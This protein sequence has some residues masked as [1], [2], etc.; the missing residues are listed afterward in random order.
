MSFPNHFIWGAA[1]SAYQI[2][3][4]PLADGAGAS[5]WHHFCQTPGHIAN[6]E[7]GDIACDHYRRYRKDIKLM[8]DLGLQMYRFSTAWGRIFPNGTGKRNQAGLD[9]YQRLV[10][11]LLSAGIAPML[12]LYHWDLPQALQE[13]GG[14][15]NPDSPK[16][17]ADYAATLF[18][19]LD[20]RVAWWVTLNEPWVVAEGGH[21]VGELAPGHQQLTEVPWVMHHQ[22]LAHLHAV[23]AYRELGKNRIGLAVNLEPQHAYTATAAD[24]AAAQRRDAYLNRFFLD[25]LLLGHYPAELAEIFGDAWPAALPLAAPSRAVPRLDFL[26]INYYAN[27][28]VRHHPTH[29][30]NAE[31]VPPAANEPQTAMG[32]RINPEALGELL[33]WVKRRYGDL[34]LIITENGS[35]FADPPLQNDTIDDTQRQA[36]LISHLQAL[37]EAIAA[38][39]N[40]QGYL[41]WSLLDNFEWHHGYSKRFGLIAVD[42][43]SQQR[44]L[45]ESAKRYRTIIANRG[46]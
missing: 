45:K 15:C 14:W 44:T 31:V 34:P 33:H 11:A 13:R 30:A 12:T 23:A 18:E 22:L 36:Y 25:P 24:Q 9:H 43:Q 6:G 27:A 16:W 20:D 40:L 41:A 4:S 29:F 21:R 38:G 35:A 2:E 7:S 19:T 39:I 32:W 37:E 5:I 42:P 10:D 8:Q 26:G 1:T 46:V 17:F 28:Y 3:G